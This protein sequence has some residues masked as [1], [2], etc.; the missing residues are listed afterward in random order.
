[1]Q[2][3]QPT[4]DIATLNVRM[5]NVEKDIELVQKQ[6]EKYV[7][8][9]MSDLLFKGMQETLDRIERDQTT[10]NTKMDNLK[11]K[12]LERAL[13]ICIGVGIGVLV[14]LISTGLVY[15]FSHIGG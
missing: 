7:P 14:A 8:Q 4:Q 1:M 12:G 10:M 5:A 6:L 9:Q 3:Q 15:V 2:P 11:T 13:S